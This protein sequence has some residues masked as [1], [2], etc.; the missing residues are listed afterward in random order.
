[1]VVHAKPLFAVGLRM[2]IGG[3]ILLGWALTRTSPRCYPQKI[4]LPYYFKLTIFG[5]FIPY[6]L[7]LWALQEVSTAK[8]AILF[9]T[10]PFFSALFGLI[11]LKEWLTKTQIIGLIIGFSGTIPV[12]F[13]TGSRLEE[14]RSWGGLSLYEI[15][16]IAAAASMSYSF[17]ITQELVKNRHCP[18]FLATGVSTLWGGLLAL[19]GSFLFETSPIKTSFAALMG[20]M[21]LQILVSNIICSNLQASLLKSYNATFLAFAGFLSPLFASIYGVILFKEELSWHFFASLFGV[22]IGLLLYTLGEKK[23]TKSA[24]Q[25]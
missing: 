23:K 15:A 21:L 25:A 18:P 2:I 7:R 20:V 19:N 5:I 1:M 22:L 16:I 24:L 10:A 13:V 6:T 3:C 17:I 12:L 14:F 11:F 4:D 8:A 9:N